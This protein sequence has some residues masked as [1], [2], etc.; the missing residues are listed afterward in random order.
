MLAAKTSPTKTF[1]AEAKSLIDGYGWPGGFDELSRVVERCAISNSTDKVSSDELKAL[2]PAIAA[3]RVPP[4]HQRWD[5][6]F[7]DGERKATCNGW[8][9]TRPGSKTQILGE[10]DFQVLKFLVTGACGEACTRKEAATKLK[11]RD[12]TYGPALYRLRECLKQKQFSGIGVLFGETARERRGRDRHGLLT[13]YENI[14]V[15]GK[16]VRLPPSEPAAATK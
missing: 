9:V 11:L 6:H 5:F 12:D 1:D 13:S 16:R 3:P 8:P 14:S 4:S 10:T 15:D 7:D 2:F